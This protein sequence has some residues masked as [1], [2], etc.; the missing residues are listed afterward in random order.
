MKLF[1]KCFELLSA[2]KINYAKCELICV[3]TPDSYIVSLAI[4]FGCKVG[5]FPSKYLGG[6]VLFGAS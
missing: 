6:A 3:W 4:A 5:K 1:S 2:S